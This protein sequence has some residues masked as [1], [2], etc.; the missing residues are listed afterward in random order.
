MEIV[1]NV[2][3]KV[4]DEDIKDGTFIIPDRVTSI[5]E[6]AFSGCTSLVTITIPESV[7]SIGRGAFY[8]C[9][10]LE[11]IV[12]S[13]S[14]T[15]IG[16]CAFRDCWLLKIINIPEGVTSIGRGAFYNCSSLE[17]IVIPKGVTS[18]G[19]SAFSY[20]EALETITLPDGLTSIGKDAFYRCYALKTIT[21][22]DSL[23]SIGKYAFY[24]CYTLK[25]ITL[26]DGVTS[27]GE[28]TFSDCT[29]LITIT[30]PESVT[31]IGE[32]TFSDCTSLITITI[33]E[34]VT[35]IGESAFSGCTLLE[36]IT[37]PKGVT[38]IGKDAFY[39]CYALKTITLPD[40]VTSI[41]E[42]AFSGCTLL[43]TIT[44]PKGV[45]SIG[46]YTFSGCCL[47]EAITLPDSLT[48][49]G[50]GAFENC[51]SL[52]SVTLPDG[53]SNIGESAFS[54]CN[55]LNQLIT[56]YGSI[57]M[58]NYD[59]IRSYLYLYVNY[60]LKDKYSDFNEFVGNDYINRIINT[61]LL[62]EQ[63][64][65]IKFKNLFYKLR[66]NYDIPRDFFETL[67]LEE[68]EKFDYKIWNKIKN[69]IDIDNIEMAEAVSEMIAIFGLFE[70]DNGARDRL[71]DYMDFIN[72]KNIILTNNMSD[73][74]EPVNYTYY[75]LKSGIIIPDEFN[76]DLSEYL[77][78]QEMKNIKKLTGNYGKTINDFVKENYEINH[79]VGFRIEENFDFHSDGNF[80]NYSTLHRMF[81]GCCKKFDV[82]F[83][84]F[85]MKYMDTILKS[86]V[87]QRRMKDI[88]KNFQSIKAYYKLHAGTDEITL[89]QAINY[90]ENIE[91]NNVYEGNM[92]FAKDVKKAG[93]VD[94]EAFEY[95]QRIFEANDKRKLTSLVKR[96]NIYE[97]NGYKI[98]TELLRKD[99]S[100]GMLVGEANYTNCC[101][102]FGGIGHNCLAHAVNSDDGG[103]FVTK[104]VTEDGEI[105]LTESWD[106]QNNNVYCHDNI[107]GTPY[108]K[109]NKYLHDAVAKAIE[110]DA[111]EI[112]RKSKEEV[113][114]YI[115][116]RKKKIEK[117]LLSK[118]EK[119]RE[120]E[121]LSEL[122]RREV[123]RLVTVG[124]GNSDL[125]LSNY[126]PNTINVAGTNVF[127]NQVFTLSHFQPA[128]YN[129][130]QVY[131]NPE[132]SAYSDA[133][134]IQ[135]IIAGS[136]EELSL[137][138]LEPLVPIY[139]D[140]R[141]VIEESK[142]NIRDYTFHK[143]KVMEE[144]IYPEDMQLYTDDNSLEDS[145][146]ILG[147]DWY[148]VYE[149]RDNNSIYISDLARTEPE[150]EDEKGIQNKEIMSSLNSLL[151]TY[152]TIEADLKEDT[153]YLLYL[154]NKKLG[155]IE[156]IGE[157]TS[158][159]F[160]NRGNLTIISENDQADILKNIKQIRQ[161]KNP[162]LIMHHI[163]FKKKAKTLDNEDTKKTR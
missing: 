118:E 60:I 152:D 41:G 130:T 80:V 155:Y 57:E 140:E 64:A 122:E 153:S 27:I 32:Y 54:G 22:P 29:S 129:S 112:I 154:M 11:T 98:K 31:S 71:Q 36:T 123:I 142:D 101:Q 40:G 96:S 77:T 104:L 70:N 61:D 81:D 160:G 139:R 25:T 44:I 42:S 43:E 26:P 84:N 132:E 48:N 144:K 23:T 1:N 18:I 95:Y 114:K 134:S 49:M 148:L 30:I 127:N 125:N 45:T 137:G 94:Q 75:Q 109:N 83:Y 141:R 147:E 47:L 46:E 116:E 150:L 50:K 119:D 55:S 97:I 13:G 149:E 37:I 131:F 105:L 100:F 89:K 28:Y 65:V 33:P 156:Q 10:S 87:Y 38:S 3:V 117:S 63:D 85:F 21:L 15:S 35:N 110:L 108:F 143:M 145:H 2:L 151:E 113:E 115:I 62:Y 161:D 52:K 82:D 53:L 74:T 120:L 12:I 16:K 56:P 91:F 72:N 92:E 79:A 59:V 66:K 159:L 124:S 14:V 90:I 128:N 4:N 126:Y 69:L 133:S 102:V 162:N 5:G 88:Q 111:L 157:D 73:D 24:R 99:D 39:R 136:V 67:S 34:G 138:E 163:K 6:Y 20:C 8:F 146:I 9:S 17:T 158:Y 106:W 51:S 19:D 93:V 86:E 103:I 78:M 76:I 68:T 121:E 135:Y 7:T 107:E 58:R